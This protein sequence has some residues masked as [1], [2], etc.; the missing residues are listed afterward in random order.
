MQNRESF[1][2]RGLC[3]AFFQAVLALAICCAPALANDVSEKE[4]HIQSARI[5]I[6]NTLKVGSWATAVIVV[7]KV[8][9][10]SK[11]QIAVQAPDPDGYNALFLSP[12]LKAS[13][14]GK[15]VT[16]DFQTGRLEGEIAVLLLRSGEEVE[17]KTLRYGQRVEYGPQVLR[18]STHYIATCGKLA[19]FKDNWQTESSDGDQGQSKYDVVIQEL[20]SLN[21]LPDQHFALTSLNAIVL[22]RKFDLTPTQSTAL[23]EW[24][25]RGGH[26]LIA[27]GDNARQYADS[28]LAGWIPI[29]VTGQTWPIRVYSGLESYAS[30]NVRIT[31]P[32]AAQV[33]EMK[34]NDA[35]TLATGIGNRPILARTNFGQGLITVLAMDIHQGPLTSWR[36]L[37]LFL[38]KV[39]LGESLTQSDDE[40]STQGQLAHSGVTDLATQLHASQ[41]YFPD[42]QSFSLWTVLGFL[43]LYMIV[44]GPLDF[45][46]MH[47]MFRKPKLTWITFPLSVIIAAWLAVYSAQNHKGSNLVVNQTNLIDVDVAHNR[48]DGKSWATIYSPRTERYEIALEPKIEM[49]TDQ[50][51]NRI[52]WTAPAEDSFG[53]TYR[54]DGLDFGGSTYQFGHQLTMAKNVPIPAWSTRSLVSDWSFLPASNPGDEARPLVENR[55]SATGNGLLT[56]TLLHHLPGELSDW[57]IA[58]RHRVY[59]PRI[60]EGAESRTTDIPAGVIWSP[61]SEDVYPD[62]LRS[63]LTGE[64]S[65]EEFN[66]KHNRTD[67][68]VEQRKYNLM[69]RNRNRIFQMLTFHEVVGGKDYTSLESHALGHLDLT[70]MLQLDCAVLFARLDSIRSQVSINQAAIKPSQES[71]FVRIVLPVS[72]KQSSAQASASDNERH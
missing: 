28:P 29:E 5:G 44:I 3:A 62:D 14:S 41:Q 54:P 66:R 16:V 19:G 59:R 23:R 63:F 4:P 27:V 56:G 36:A 60:P 61:D 51:S 42:I 33:A 24:T 46:L 55:L 48:I 58:Y 11:S 71:T 50:V 9:E 32:G 31:Y 64:F 22:G 8:T 35:T 1:T 26:L 34:A 18:Q 37:D 39:L 43:V 15:S 49:Q 2:L 72:L 38:Q 45:L 12:I 10:G 67:Y 40:P 65:R 47:R 52:C 30:S 20:E 25:R 7:D 68:T 21:R 70:Q 53:G 17:R 13:D 6:Q 69:E 57:L